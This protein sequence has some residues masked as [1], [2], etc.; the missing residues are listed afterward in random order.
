MTRRTKQRLV[1]TIRDVVS[2]AGVDCAGQNGDEI[3]VGGVVGG[4]MAGVPLL[5]QCHEGPPG[6]GVGQVA[7][8]S[9]L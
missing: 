5:L 7:R 8:C 2:Q 4:D 3:N 9:N 1:L 6:G